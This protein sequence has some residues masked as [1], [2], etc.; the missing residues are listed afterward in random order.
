MVLK[1]A[2]EHFNLHLCIV[3]RSLDDLVS[4]FDVI[5]W[6]DQEYKM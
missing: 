5:N 6:S 2:V 3:I 1:E 4:S